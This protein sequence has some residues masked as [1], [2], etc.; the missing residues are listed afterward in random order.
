MNDDQSVKASK[1][2][3]DLIFDTPADKIKELTYLPK[4][5]PVVL[6]RQMAMH[7][8][9]DDTVH[10]RDEE[11]NIVRYVPVDELA[12]Q[13]YLQLCRSVGGEHIK[14]GTELASMFLANEEEMETYVQ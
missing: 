13:Y 5:T 8:L 4:G 14:R 2:L 3:L 10:R 12:V 6:A 7:H 1:H 9:F 11:G